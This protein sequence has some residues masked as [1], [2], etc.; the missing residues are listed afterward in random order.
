MSP[1]E[2][3]NDRLLLMEGSDSTE[4]P[5]ARSQDNKVTLAGHKDYEV[6]KGPL[7]GHQDNEFSMAG[8]QHNEVLFPGHQDYKVPMAVHQ[9]FDIH[10]N[11]TGNP[12]KFEYPK[13][14]NGTVNR[15]DQIPNGWVTNGTEATY[16]PLF[17]EKPGQRKLD[18]HTGQVKDPVRPLLNPTGLYDGPTNDQEAPKG[19]SN[20]VF[21][22]EL[23][24]E[25]PPKDCSNN[26]PLKEV[27]ISSEPLNGIQNG[28]QED[29]ESK[30]Q[31]EINTEVC[32]LWYFIPL[33]EY[34]YKQYVIDNYLFY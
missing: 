11:N 21:Q 15:F 25:G 26:Q 28:I 7:A 31:Q 10:C 30:N 33:F 18:L 19:I 5:E 9:D 17:E 34:I 16:H 8:H 23:E 24:H 22:K 6:P 13:S 14:P 12:D 3:R 27:H 1:C 2:G 29:T 4:A 20:G 32:I